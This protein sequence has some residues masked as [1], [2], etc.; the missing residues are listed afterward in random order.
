MIMG[1]RSRDTAVFRSRLKHD[2]EQLQYLFEAGLVGDEWR[3]YYQALNR[4]RA[5]VEASR[6]RHD[7]GP[8]SCAVSAEDLQPI[9][10]VV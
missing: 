2:A 1:V 6:D 9:A 10:S 5:K 7:C 8:K 3:P 4:V